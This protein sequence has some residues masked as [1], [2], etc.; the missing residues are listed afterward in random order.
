[1]TPCATPRFKEII[2]GGRRRLNYQSI[3]FVAIIIIVLYAFY[4]I[5]REES[6]PNN[7][8]VIKNST[9]SSLNELSL[10][11][12]NSTAYR[13]GIVQVVGSNL[14]TYETAR[15]S[16][17]CYSTAQNYEFHSLT[18]DRRQKYCSHNDVSFY[19]LH[20]KHKT[21]NP[22]IENINFGGQKFFRRHCLVAH[23]LKKYK[24]LDYVL[25]IDSDIGVINP[26]RSFILNQSDVERKEIITEN[27]WLCLP[28]LAKVS[29]ASF[30]SHHP[31]ISSELL[32]NSSLL[33]FG[34]FFCL[35]DSIGNLLR[36]PTDIKKKCDNKIMTKA[37]IDNNQ[38]LLH[39]TATCD[40]LSDRIGRTR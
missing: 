36:R 13:I 5:Q 6:L 10:K 33:L 14:F 24:N 12:R 34:L 30:L 3:I 40:R 25:F 7:V 35:S 19:I 11:V 17:Q 16:V 26:K 32:K 18:D 20:N 39:F 37:V 2:M 15:N 28:L 4:R 38:K 31:I 22:F 1:M 9:V 29:N 27:I 8:Y 21:I 23:F